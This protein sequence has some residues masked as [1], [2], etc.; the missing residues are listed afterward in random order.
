MLSSSRR[1]QRPHWLACVSKHRQR[2]WPFEPLQMDVELLMGFAETCKATMLITDITDLCAD[3]EHVNT[4]LHDCMLY[5]N[6]SMMHA[7]Y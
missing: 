6:V 4:T 5:H 3:N 7:C 2:T 1:V